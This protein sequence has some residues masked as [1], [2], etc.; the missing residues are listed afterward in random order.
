MFTYNRI[1][2]IARSS[3]GRLRFAHF[4]DRAVTLVRERLMPVVLLLLVACGGSPSS[5][6]TPVDDAATADV[7]VQRFLQAVADSN[8]VRM[9]RY[10]GTA[11]GPASITHEPSDYEDRLAVAQL[12]LRQAPFR[13]V[14]SDKVTGDDSRMIVSV[15]LDRTQCTRSVPFTAVRTEKHGWIVTSIDLTQAGTPG[16]PCDGTQPR[17]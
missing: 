7:A 16:R 5:A 13:V 3:G 2:I 10:W 17:Q 15:D 14:R 6:P 4:S 9:G 12:Y 1:G 11:H 8:V